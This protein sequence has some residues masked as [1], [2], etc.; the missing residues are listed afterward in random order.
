MVANAERLVY[1]WYS[2][3]RRDAPSSG[4]ILSG[5]MKP[6]VVEI[7]TSRSIPKAKVRAPVSMILV[8]I[9]V[10]RARQLVNHGQLTHVQLSTSFPRP[11]HASHRALLDLEC[12]GGTTAWGSIELI[13]NLQ[14]TTTHLG[15]KSSQ[16]KSSQVK[17][18][19]NSF[20]FKEWRSRIRLLW[21]RAPRSLAT[22]PAPRVER[23]RGLSRSFER[24][25]LRSLPKSR[26]GGRPKS[27]A[28]VTGFLMKGNCV[29]LS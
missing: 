19:Q 27:C 5:S 18:S 7:W 26:T 21:G 28:T 29:E 16:V 17:S 9:A 14:F 2:P 15:V 20:D 24:F 8:G 22:G 13:R 12:H 10:R 11:L 1:A 6:V 25:R 4:R 23:A 3:A